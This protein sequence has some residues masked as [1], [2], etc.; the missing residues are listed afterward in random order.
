M[1]AK[2]HNL[3]I[4]EQKELLDPFPVNTATALTYKE[5]LPYEELDGLRFERLCYEI[6]CSEGRNPRYN[7]KSGQPD[8][9]VD[10]ITED[11][12]AR[13]VYQCKNINDRKSIR[14][15]IRDIQNAYTKVLRRWIE[16][17]HLP[18]PTHFVY[19]SRQ[20]LNDIEDSADYTVW[21]D[22]VLQA[23]NIDIQ[24]WGRDSLDSKLRECYSV[25]SGVFSDQVA[26]VFCN[27]LSRPRD[28]KWECLN[29]KSEYPTLR[30]F[31]SDWKENKLYVA[32][33]LKGK[34]V[35]ALSTAPVV[36]VQGHPGSGKT[37]TTLSLLAQL[38]DRPERIYYTVISNFDNIVEL[39][40]SVKKRA[41][42]PSIFILDDCHAAPDLA[43]DLIQRLKGSLLD[44]IYPISVKVILLTR[45]ITRKE[46]S[47]YTDSLQNL[48]ELE[49][50]S[51]IEISLSDR[52]SLLKVLKK[53]IPHIKGITIRHADHIFNL[54]GGNL[55]LATLTIKNITSADEL[56]R[57]DSDSVKKKAYNI[58][59]Q[60]IYTTKEDRQYMK[61]LCALAMFD[62]TPLINYLGGS[63]K[64][65][66]SGLAT[67]LYQPERIRFSHSSLAEVL[68]YVLA[69]MGSTE[70]IQSDHLN[71]WISSELVSYYIKIG[72]SGNVL[73]D[74]FF[75]NILNSRLSFPDL[76]MSRIISE[77]LGN[78]DFRAN[79]SSNHL[80]IRFSF[81]GRLLAK[82]SQVNSEVLTEIHD[83][84]Y[85]KLIHLY[86]TKNPWSKNDVEDF[87]SGL[88]TLRK[89]E[90]HFLSLQAQWSRD[91]LIEKALI[92]LS[93]IDLAFVLSNLSPFRAFELINGLTPQNIDVVFSRNL[94]QKSSIGLL[95]QAL[96]FLRNQT[97]EIEGNELNLLSEVEKKV[98]AKH[99][100]QLIVNNGT[101]YDLFRLLERLSSIRA[102]EL[103]KV[104]GSSDIDL[105]VNKTI[106]QERS[107]GTLDFTL[108]D[109]KQKRVT[110]DGKEM[111]LLAEIEKKVTAKHLLQLIVNNGTIFELFRFLQR[112]STSRADEL[113]RALSSSDID[114]LV[115]KTIEQER[116]IETIHETLNYLNFRSSSLLE[117][118]LTLLSP[119]HFAR[120]IAGAGT[121]N[122]LMDITRELPVSCVNELRLEI[123]RCPAENW[124]QIVFRGMPRNLINFL[125]LESHYYP[126]RVRSQLHT[127]VET[128]GYHYLTEQKW[129]ELDRAAYETEEPAIA[130]LREKL[131][132]FLDEV[133][134][135]RLPELD[136]K[137][138]TSAFSVLWRHAPRKHNFLS[139][140][141]WNI[142][143][144]EH[145]W[146]RDYTFGFINRV[147]NHLGHKDFD[148]DNAS[149]IFSKISEHAL[150]VNWN[151][152]HSG[153][154]FSF[155][156]AL[157]QTA[158]QF[159]P[160]NPS[161]YFPDTLT[162]KFFK[163]FDDLM[164]KKPI[165]SD[166]KISRYAITGLL[167][168]IQPGK[169]Y[170]LRTMVSDRLRGLN[171]LRDEIL[172]SL[173]SE[174]IGFAR[175]YFS[176]YG[177]GIV[178]PP[179]VN[180]SKEIKSAL[181]L[182]SQSIQH[183]TGAVEK[184][185]NDL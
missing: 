68:F 173:E 176:L 56:F 168:F 61:K 132:L 141:I 129:F 116:S 84:I 31:Y 182:R 94:E 22:S 18:R 51:V 47:T 174:T 126:D 166:D 64:V 30:E 162:D 93:L 171:Y 60:G 8:Y 146:P 54:T 145:K 106:E 23:D 151:K 102:G 184:I 167:L 79:L 27:E 58:Y 142:V 35:T 150:N 50:E 180:F 90:S 16:E 98:T 157:W 100:L 175:A 59:I 77:F 63:S 9:G 65:F 183:T 96:S 144:P 143:P 127:I 55:K 105:L 136:F 164:S 28:S 80:S 109:L 99:L 53:R 7:G 147:I 25:V 169:K 12:D 70:N 118:L 81:L 44:R 2:K 165:N 17:Q 33:I 3:S 67:I 14:E 170:E 152:V 39:V 107:V 69:D 139:T 38:K 49:R 160:S 124:R 158:Y 40:D 159:S 119:A 85:R 185:L 66:N 36:L 43:V 137:E 34:F 149:S 72:N 86:R 128:E 19:Y 110:L 178:C 130:I 13:C 57:L 6:L 42:L 138:A 74:S 41:H 154:L 156:W 103:I 121:L 89:S 97:V 92:N 125:K 76:D 148:R 4:E 120:L 101:I 140:Q 122:S 11:N 114:L 87:K 95:N 108:R 135:E 91:K 75:Q 113:I 24:L 83:F 134:V 52:F 82:A 48:L 37:T 163:L 181:K 78:T 131:E 111:N 73:V 20:R 179:R 88:F 155:S 26:N 161:K 29:T 45:I 115:D 21:R 112:S 62:I 32:P 10:I 123:S 71:K 172:N 117:A 177:M 1:N 133:S 5:S 153:L 15:S 46:G 104:V